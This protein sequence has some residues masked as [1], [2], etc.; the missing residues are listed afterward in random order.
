V[1]LD[2]DI[3]VD[4]IRNHPPA[5]AW[6][7]GLSAYP[8]VSGIAALELTYGALNAAELRAVEHFLRPFP[9]LWPMDEDVRRAMTDYALVHLSHGIDVMD[10][11]TAALAVRHGLDVA[12]FNVKHFSAIPGLTTIQ[13]YVR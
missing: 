5:R 10:A 3:L 13:P 4:L 1:L 12:T 8:T 9:I 2:T 7:A 11:I 6:F